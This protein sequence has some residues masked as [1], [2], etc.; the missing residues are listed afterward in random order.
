M[1]AI[2]YGSSS[3]VETEGKLTITGATKTI[4]QSGETVGIFLD[5]ETSPIETGKNVR[6]R[7]GKGDFINNG[8]IRLLTGYKITVEDGSGGIS[9]TKID[10][11]GNAVSSSYTDETGK[12]Y[13]NGTTYEKGKVKKLSDGVRKITTE[14]TYNATGSVTRVKERS[15]LVALAPSEAFI[16]EAGYANYGNTL[17]WQ[18]LF[19]QS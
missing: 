16:R 2:G 8:S 11:N 17:S 3:E 18:M 15:D 10:E 12:T 14:Y 1:N 5:N 7:T 4:M 6:F 19:S 9:E 13:T